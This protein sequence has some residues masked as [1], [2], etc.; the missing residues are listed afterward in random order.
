MS[1]VASIFIFESS[2]L[3]EKLKSG[4]AV[5]EICPVQVA[6]LIMFLI[7]L[8][9]LRSLA[10]TAFGLAEHEEPRLISRSKVFST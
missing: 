7:A 8:E 6:K 4:L 10:K 1:A 3:T 2:G 5:P 9:R